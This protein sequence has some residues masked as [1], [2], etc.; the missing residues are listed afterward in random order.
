MNPEQSA[1]PISERFARGVACFQNGDG[2][3]A[4]QALE[5]VI[6]EDPGYRHTDGDNPYFYLGKIHEVEDRLDTA[7]EN[8]TRALTLDSWDEESLIGRGS[9][10]T[11]RRRHADAIAD[12]KKALSIPDHLR[13]APAG[14][15]LY[16]VAE[17]LRQMGDLTGAL[18]WSRRALKADPDNFRHQELVKTV[19]R[20]LGADPLPPPGEN[21]RNHRP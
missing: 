6:D 16:A 12:F 15:L 8:Y 13:N 9:C 20:A 18:D 14:Q 2:V 5:S 21:D 4:V 10:L 7:I 1:R 3:G 19:A 17:N 11:V